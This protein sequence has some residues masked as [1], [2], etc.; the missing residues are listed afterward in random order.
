MKIADTILEWPKW[1]VFSV[2][3]GLIL[4]IGWLDYMSEFGL[5][6]F[7]FYGVPIFTIGWIGHRRSAVIIAAISGVI[8]YAANLPTQPYL[9]HEAYLWASINRAAYFIFVAIGGAAMRA[10]RDESRARLEALTRTRELEQ[11]I[12]RVSEREQLRIGQ[13]LHDGLCQSLAAIDCAAA[14]LKADLDLRRSPES[15]MAGTIQKMLKEAVVEARKVARGIFPVQ[16]DTAGLSV[17]L[18]E[19]V[20]TTNRLRQTSATFEARGEIQVPDPR[21]AMNLYRI[22]QEALS[23]A[24]RHAGAEHVSIDLCQDGQRLALTIADD[25]CGFAPN[26]PG[27]RGMGLRTMRYRAQLIGAEFDISSESHGGTVVRCTVEVPEN[28]AV[29]NLNVA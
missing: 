26:M 21:V 19:L 20:S 13:D 8:W 18:D 12:V 11:E 16:V 15:G 2:S 27:N 29:E 22:A 10:Q 25:G 5:S 17:A 14:C 7:I 4:G 3:I 1:V 9:T 24:V 23:N 28:A 6:F